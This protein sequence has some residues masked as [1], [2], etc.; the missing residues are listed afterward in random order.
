[1]S[2]GLKSSVLA[3]AVLALAACGGSGGF[4]GSPGVRVSP[5]GIQVLAG[6]TQQMT[7]TASDGGTTF[8]WQVNGL[9]GG[10]ATIGTIS[11]SGLYTA[12]GLPPSGGTVTIGAIEQGMS[13]AAGSA[14]LNIGYSNA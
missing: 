14:I 13:G 9:T 10:N 1:M 2:L 12:P 7:A 6:S 8:I 3:A 4:S 11:S 5:S